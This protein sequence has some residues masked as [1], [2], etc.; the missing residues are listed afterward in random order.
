MDNLSALPPRGELDLT[1]LLPCVNINLTDLPPHGELTVSLCRASLTPREGLNY[2]L[3][4]IFFVSG[5]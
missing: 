2:L 5:F 3:M 4:E 1:A